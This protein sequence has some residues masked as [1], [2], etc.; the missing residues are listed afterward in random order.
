LFKQFQLGRRRKRH[1][2]RPGRTTRASCSCT[3]GARGPGA[4]PAHEKT[5]TGP[6]RAKRTRRDRP[7][8]KS[9]RKGPGRSRMR[10]DRSRPWPI[11]E[12]RTRLRKMPDTV[13]LQSLGLRN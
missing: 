10:G 7:P 5:S 3:G 9:S 13:V 11:P 6:V 2:H 1:G 4:G 8:A 12:H